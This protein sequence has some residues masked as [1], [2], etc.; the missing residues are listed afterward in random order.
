MWLRDAARDL[1]PLKRISYS[2]PNPAQYNYVPNYLGPQSLKGPKNRPN[3]H[4]FTAPGC[5]FAGS[6]S[7]PIISWTVLS[8]QSGLIIGS[9]CEALS[10]SSFRDW[11]TQP[12]ELHVA[13]DKTIG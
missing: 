5:G 6:D 1:K 3:F 10:A 4:P 7:V 2:A 9:L 12:V 13:L 8:R 11:L